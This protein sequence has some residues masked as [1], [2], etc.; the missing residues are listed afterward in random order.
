[1]H[2]NHDD[3]L[4]AALKHLAATARDGSSPAAVSA[5]TARGERVRRRRI[6]TLALTGLLLAGGVSGAV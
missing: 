3:P 1:M 5:I 2:E 6:A 4:A